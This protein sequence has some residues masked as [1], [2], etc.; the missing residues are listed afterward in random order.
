[1]VATQS[2]FLPFFEY[3]GNAFELFSIANLQKKH[4]LSQIFR[5]YDKLTVQM[6]LFDSVSTRLH[7][8]FVGEKRGSV[9]YSLLS[10]YQNHIYDE[11]LQNY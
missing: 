3:H 9:I 7:D 2:Y 4:N 5:A 1:M 8:N 10:T 6:S 11:K